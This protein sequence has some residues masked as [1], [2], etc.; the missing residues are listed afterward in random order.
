VLE[1]CGRKDYQKQL[2]KELN[3]IGNS[4]MWR[5]GAAT[6]NLRPKESAKKITKSTKGVGG[7]KTN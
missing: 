4:E 5:A 1:S 6:R 2:T 3:E 7:R